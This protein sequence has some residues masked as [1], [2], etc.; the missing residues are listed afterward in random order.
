MAKE[1]LRIPF[2]RKGQFHNER[3]GRIAFDD[4]FFSTLI[5]NFEENRKG[6]EPYARYGHNVK[7][8]GIWAGEKS[9]GHCVKVEEDGD[10]LVGYFDPTND[11][12]VSEVDRGEYRYSSAEI[13]V[14]A[15]DPNSG[16]RIGP[17]LKGVGL[18]NEP[19]IPGLHRTSIVDSSKVA[20]VL[21]DD[22]ELVYTI[23]P[24]AGEPMPSEQDKAPTEN[25]PET[26]KAPAPA[27][28]APSESVVEAIKLGF[29]GFKEDL[30]NFFAQAVTPAQPT[31]QEPAK[32]EEQEPAP[33]E[34]PKQEEPTV[35]GDPSAKNPPTPDPE[36]EK[37][38]EKLAEQLAALQ[39]QMKTLSDGQA[40]ALEAVKSEAQAVKV[41]A[42]AAADAAKAEAAAAKEEALKLKA[43]AENK[44]LE[45]ALTDRAKAL[46]LGGT[47]PMLA[48]RAAN[49]VKALKQA[50]QSEL[51]L[52]DGAN[53][54]E[55][56][57][58]LADAAGT[59]TYGTVGKADANSAPTVSSQAQ[60]FLAG[61]GKKA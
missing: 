49:I 38:N 33:K 21:A 35:S 19:S 36:E 51:Q 6:Y 53:L 11:E 37:M 15:L 32:A 47:P 26:N 52:G 16:E 8:L 56:I 42:E 28:A 34:Q 3:H 60:A 5:R 46:V 58:A 27:A 41:A 1:L 23:Q 43:A 31:A 40:A 57:W 30:K 24:L 13:V 54:E 55:E 50:G 22:A 9:L 12:V 17:V 2:L 48:N 10:E 4:A 25:A 59:V 45:L 61:I 39:A 18:T 29:A 7:G 20:L 14:D 44:Q